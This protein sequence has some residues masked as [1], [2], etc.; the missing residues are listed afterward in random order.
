MAA[1]YGFPIYHVITM[2]APRAMIH[3]V[4]GARL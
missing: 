2:N 4:S 3:H 1:A